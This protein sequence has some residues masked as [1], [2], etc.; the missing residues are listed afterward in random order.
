MRIWPEVGVAS[1]PMHLS[2][3]CTI[4]PGYCIQKRGFSRAG[5]PHHRRKLPPT[6][7]EGHLFQRLHLCLA[8]AVGLAQVF[9]FQDFHRLKTSLS[10][11]IAEEPYNPVN[12]CLQFRKEGSREGGPLPRR[13]LRRDHAA[14]PLHDGLGQ[15]EAQADPRRIQGM[16]APVKPLENVVDILRGDAVAVVRHPDLEHSR[17]A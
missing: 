3:C 9:Y 6:Q 4:H 15:R 7:G 17:G 13:T 11:R 2:A 1:A 14:L 8:G 12:F 10:Q 16:A 5:L